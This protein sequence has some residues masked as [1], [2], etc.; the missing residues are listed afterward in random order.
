MNITLTPEME[1]IVSRKVQSGQ[2]D[3]PD[4]VIDKGLRLLEQEETRQELHFQ[5]LK[6]EIVLGLEQADNGQVKAF[7]PEELLHRVRQK[8]AKG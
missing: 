4:A 3:S 2:Y 8:L 6:Q 5:E 1:Q 7:A